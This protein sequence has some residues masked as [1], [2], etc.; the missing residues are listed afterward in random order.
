MVARSG[1]QVTVPGAPAWQSDGLEPPYRPRR[2][3]AS[4][5]RRP[6]ITSP[7]NPSIWGHKKNSWPATLFLQAKNSQNEAKEGGSTP[8]PQCHMA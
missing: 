7:D 4:E 1:L 6:R 2:T 3:R 8:T 5:A